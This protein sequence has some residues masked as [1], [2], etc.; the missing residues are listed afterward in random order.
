MPKDQ[1]A[2]EAP[3][4]AHLLDRLH[5]T[6]D[7]PLADPN[8]NGESGADVLA[9]IGG[10]RIGIQVTQIDNAYSLPDAAGP[11]TGHGA[12][13]RLANAQQ[14]YAGFAENDPAKIVANI[15]AALH[16][17][18]LHR[19]TGFDELWLLVAAGVPENGGVISTFILSAHL[20]LDKLD[21]ATTP[22]LMQSSY[23]RAFLLPV[24]GVERALF[25]WAKPSGPWSLHVEQDAIPS[26]SFAE[27]VASARDA[28]QSGDLDAWTDREIAKVLA[29]LRGATG[30]GVT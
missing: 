23:S 22:D 17:K 10:R 30:E 7:A 29:E 28:A 26:L 3:L 24:L 12:E 21:A 1:F 18:A 15:A 5:I 11:I 14:P 6:P 25:E 4:V 20:P 27:L 9:I 2:H 19:V 8:T 13:K 16:P